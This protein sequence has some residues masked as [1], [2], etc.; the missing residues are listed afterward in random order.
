[1]ERAFSGFEILL[2][3]CKNVV[4]EPES[5]FNGICHEAESVADLSNY[6]GG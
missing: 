6:A 1:M 3:D 2:N 5:D 4:S